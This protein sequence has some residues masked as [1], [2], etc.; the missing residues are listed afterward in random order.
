MLL[1]ALLISTNVSD[2]MDVTNFNDNMTNLDN[3]SDSAITWDNVDA[4]EEAAKDLEEVPLV[5]PSSGGERGKFLTLSRPR[6][7]PMT[8]KIVWR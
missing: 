5:R 1:A 7:F 4:M 2:K 8:S 3:D 6:G